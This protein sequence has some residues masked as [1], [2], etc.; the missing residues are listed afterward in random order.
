MG[1]D[2]GF[3]NDGEIKN[4]G[5]PPPSYEDTVEMKNVI[6]V[7]S[8]EG[9]KT[10]ENKDDPDEKTKEEEKEKEKEKEEEFPPVGVLELVS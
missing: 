6:K 10:T 4:G 9:D 7:K 8:A 2:E 5:T 1:Q 3:Q